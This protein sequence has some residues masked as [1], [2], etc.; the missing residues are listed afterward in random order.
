MVIL[1]SVAD[2]IDHAYN[3]FHVPRCLAK[4]LKICES[5]INNYLT[6]ISF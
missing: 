6:M 5:C 2:E 1:I 3:Y 4:G